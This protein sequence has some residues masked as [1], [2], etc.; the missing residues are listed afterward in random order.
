MYF[1]PENR[2]VFLVLE[3]VFF[4]R[5]GLLVRTFPPKIVAKT[6]VEKNASVVFV[7][8]LFYKKPKG[9]FGGVSQINTQHSARRC[10]MRVGAVGV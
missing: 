5:K 9:G 1:A 3:L 8:V 6:V 2:A 7:L 4:W 10:Q